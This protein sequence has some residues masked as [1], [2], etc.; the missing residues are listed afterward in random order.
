MKTYHFNSR[1]A[2]DLFDEEIIIA[3]LD[4]GLY[5]TLNGT[6]LHV[7]NELP[8]PNIETVMESVTKLFPS[9]IKEVE[10][11]LTKIWKELLDEKLIVFDESEKNQKNIEITPPSEFVPSKLSRYA[12]MQDLLMLD[13]IHEVDEEGWVAKDKEGTPA[14]ETK[15]TQ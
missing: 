9:M 6:I 1:V 12:D 5:Y 11:D 7:I 3:N 2:A 4:S 14:D 10:G 15:D 13:P 8:F